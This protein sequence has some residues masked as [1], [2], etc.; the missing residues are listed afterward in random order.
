MLHTKRIWR[1]KDVASEE[2]L[3]ENL[4]EKTWTLCR[5]FR[6]CGYLF[7]NDS[8]SEDA[9]QEYGIVKEE[10]LK[11]VETITVSWCSF[12]SCLKRIEMI[13]S[14]KYDLPWNPY[15]YIQKRQIQTP[16]EH[17]TCGFCK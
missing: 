9:I 10:S 15:G 4:I 11:Q 17:Q 14:G 5:G 16:E 3:A 1:V 7:L 13:C 6:F 8:T 2:E 12:E